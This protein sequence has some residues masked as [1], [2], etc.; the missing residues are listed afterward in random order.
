[1]DLS[2]AYY[3]LSFAFSIAKLEDYGVSKEKLFECYLENRA[4]LTKVAYSHSF[5]YNLIQ[6]VLQDSMLRLPL[7]NSFMNTFVYLIEKN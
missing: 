4:Q 6:G 3:C 7:F 2:K 5:R 1:M